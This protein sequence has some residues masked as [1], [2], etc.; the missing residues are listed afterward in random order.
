M[1]RTVKKLE[2]CR[3]EVTIAF[4][5]EEWKAARKAAF[6]KMAKNVEIKG[7]R[8]GHA[9]EQL[10][11][12]RISEAELMN[13][14]LD[15][16]LQ[17]A[18]TKTIQEE[19]LIP[20]ARPSVNVTKISDTEC[21]VVITIPTAPEIKLGKYKGLEIGHN[22]VK[23]SDNEL[24]DEINK[25]LLDN[26]ELVLKEDAA[27]KGDTVVIDFEG[28]I[29]GKAFDGGKAENYSLELGSNAF[30]PGF[31]DQLVGVKAEEKRDVVVTFP[32]NY[33]NGLNNKEA[34]FKVTVHEVKFKK[35]P[36]LN[37]EF[38]EELNIK[39]VKTAAQYREFVKK[40]LEAKAAQAES[41]RYFDALLDAIVNDSEVKIPE[42][43]VDEEAEGMFNNLKSQIEQNGLDMDAYFKI[44]NSKE[45]DVKAKMKDDARKNIAR[46]FVMEEIAKSEEIEVTETNLEFEIAKM[47][48]QY[49]MEP[50][51]IKEIV[52]QNK[53]RFA[54]DIK[55]R[56]IV[57]LLQQNNN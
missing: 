6:D 44:T 46:Y 28:F 16:L 5:Q 53:E 38:V 2:N 54:N 47:A 31:E 35:V 42:E 23:V 43:F 45:E 13:K 25:R 14:A 1:Q 18:Y 9:P 17:D 51:K 39:D 52:Y 56:Q 19:N 40:D 29:D 49:G 27:V 12:D 21:E 10:V 8:K 34:T 22:E 57:T 33:P 41:N 3:S 15:E 55:Q 11:K 32:D 4:E 7:F 37:D 48:E 36:E 50:E 20:V 26:A 30:I 24:K